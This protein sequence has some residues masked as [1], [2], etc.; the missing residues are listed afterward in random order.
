MYEPDPNIH[1][2]TRLRIMMILSGVSEADF[3]F[4][5]STL[6]LTNGNLSIQAAKLE[7]AGYIDIT[8][9]FEGKIPNTRYRLT[10]LGRKRLAAYWQG[11]DEIRASGKIGKKK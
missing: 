8:K 2:P 10:D 9:S 4:L 6:G 11:M 5:L 3:K 7:E 1:Q